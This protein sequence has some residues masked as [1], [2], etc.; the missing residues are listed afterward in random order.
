MLRLCDL[1]DMIVVQ[2]D[3]IDI[4]GIIE[5]ARPEFAHG[6][7]D[8]PRPDRRLFRIGQHQ[9]TR[10]AGLAQQMVGRELQRRLRQFTERAGHPFQRPCPGDVGQPDHQGGAPFGDPQPGH[11]P[12]HVA[13]AGQIPAQVGDQFRHG[14]VPVRRQHAAGETD[15][16]QQG[17]GQER[18][19][20][21]H[22]FQQGAAGRIGGIFAG[23]S[24]DLGIGMAAGLAS[25][26]FGRGGSSA[27]TISGVFSLLGGALS[28]RAGAVR[29]N[30]QSFDMQAPG[31][32]ARGGPTRYGMPRFRLTT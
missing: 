5:F 10:I 27:V 26:G 12:R 18:A 20:A 29:V 2:N 28:L 30:R 22:R 19:V 17:L 4:A 7:N 15:I 16:G 14:N 3:E 6:Q 24:L 25:A 9:Q 8:Q 21:E 32:W 31:M 13:F 11:Q 1:D 23:E